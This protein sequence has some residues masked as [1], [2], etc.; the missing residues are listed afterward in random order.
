MLGSQAGRQIDNAQ[1]P[2]GEIEIKHR[3]GVAGWRGEDGV[4]WKHGEEFIQPELSPSFMYV[5]TPKN[6]CKDN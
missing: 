3:R 1:R 2:R 5:L 6:S 4:E